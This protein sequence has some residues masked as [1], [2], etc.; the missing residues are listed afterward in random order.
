MATRP[1]SEHS[2]RAMRS[3]CRIVEV[4][5]KTAAEGEAEVESADAAVAVAWISERAVTAFAT[6]YLFIEGMLG[7]QSPLIQEI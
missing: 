4:M 6:T 2:L 7:K 1:H 5:A 3:L